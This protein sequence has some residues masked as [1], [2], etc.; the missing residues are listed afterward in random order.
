MLPSSSR[1]YVWW[2]ECWGGGRA[3][4]VRESRWHSEGGDRQVA[5]KGKQRLTEAT[6]NKLCARMNADYERYLAAM[7][8]KVAC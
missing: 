6:A 8:S 3:W 1:F 4:T 2:I 5:P 7:R